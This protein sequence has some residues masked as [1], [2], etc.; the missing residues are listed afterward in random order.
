MK[1]AGSDG[2]CLRCG[3]P[4]LPHPRCEA[5]IVEAEQR[6]EQEQRAWDDA[7]LALIHAMRFP[8]V[9]LTLAASSEAEARRVYDA[10]KALC[11]SFESG[12]FRVLEAEA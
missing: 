8:G 4:N 12:T 11:E 3:R 9:K 5:A 10:A 6:I 1:L 2:R 7:Q